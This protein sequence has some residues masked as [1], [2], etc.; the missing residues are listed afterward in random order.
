MPLVDTYALISM[1]SL[2]VFTF[3]VP[4]SIFCEEALDPLSLVFLLWQAA[5]KGS[6]W[7]FLLFFKD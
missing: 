7:L 3:H 5:H 6:P 1:A 4:N 2:S